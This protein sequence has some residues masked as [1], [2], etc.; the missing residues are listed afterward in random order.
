MGVLRKQAE[1][2]TAQ[3]RVMHSQGK[4][5]E[6]LKAM[7]A[8]ELRGMTQELRSALIN[9]DPDKIWEAADA[10]VKMWGRIPENATWVYN[11]VDHWATLRNTAVLASADERAQDHIN[12]LLA[13]NDMRELPAHSEEMKE[14]ARKWMPELLGDLFT[15]ADECGIDLLEAIA[16]AQER[17][18]ESK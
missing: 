6:M 1:T 13:S 3:Q 16:Y 7:S 4:E 5:Y 18:A 9:G 8:P 12:M 17:R 14:A 10:A 11:D 2:R 15:Y